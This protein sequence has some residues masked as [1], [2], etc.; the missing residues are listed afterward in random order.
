MQTK[1]FSLFFLTCRLIVKSWSRHIKIYYRKVMRSSP[2]TLTESIHTFI[3]DAAGSVLS[4]RELSG[5][6]RE[7]PCKVFLAFAIFMR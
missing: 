6:Q 7:N 3:Q 4:P 2:N 1:E 5:R